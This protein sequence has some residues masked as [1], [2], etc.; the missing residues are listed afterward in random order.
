MK[1]LSNRLAAAALETALLGCLAVAMVSAKGSDAAGA[2]F[3]ILAA[4]ETEAL[5]AKEGQKVV[6][7]GETARSGRSKSGTHFVNFKEAEFYLIAF[8]TDLA[9]FGPTGEPAVAYDGKRLAVTGVVTLYQG[10][11]QIKLTSPD[12][13][14]VLAADEPWPRAPAPAPATSSAPAT[15]GPEK[16]APTAAK[17]P[18][19]PK[20]KPPVDA[21]LYFK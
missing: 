10:K 8:K 6:V 14:R 4:T 3:P 2:A 7:F 20:K 11:P 1:T 21:K 17:A 13:V 16:P 19:E 5:K 18:E 9:A 15:T 12:Q